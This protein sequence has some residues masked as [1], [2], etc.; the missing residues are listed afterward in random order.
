MATI[1]REA[2]ISKSQTIRSIQGLEEKGL[3]IVKRKTTK[4]NERKTNHYYFNDFT[5]L[6]DAKTV[7][8]L[9]IIAEEKRRPLTD[10]EILDKAMK[11]DKK[12]RKSCINS[13]LKNFKKKKSL[14]QPNRLK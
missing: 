3:L 10:D 2:R 9:K 7:D 8:E 11:I 14:E 12:K 4:Y 1:S 13:L 5:D 6:W